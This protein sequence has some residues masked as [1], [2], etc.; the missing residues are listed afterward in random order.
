MLKAINRKQIENFPEN[1]STFYVEHDIDA[2]ETGDT[3]HTFILNDKFVKGVGASEAK[4]LEIM[5]ECGFTK[6]R[7]ELGVGQLSGGWKMRL[8]LARAM[9]C[10]ADILLLGA[11][12]RLL[13]CLTHLICDGIPDEPT[14]HLDVGSVAWL[15]DYLKSQT[16]VTV[17]VV[18][19]DSGFLDSICTDVVHYENKRL[20]YYKGALHE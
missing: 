8:A 1:L 4:V 12:S 11:S 13:K 14:N 15:Q 6:E 19:H 7:R 2:N 3:C 18:S 17:M 20:V 9:V 16:H 5:E 10:N